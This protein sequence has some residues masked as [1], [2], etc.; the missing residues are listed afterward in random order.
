MLDH[1]QMWF[2]L[3]SAGRK[4]P[5]SALPTTLG[6]DPSSGACLR[7]P[8]VKPQHAR[9]LPGDNTTL[10]LE[11]CPGALVELDGWAVTEADLHEGDEL[12]VGQ[13]HVRLERDHSQ[14]P[15]RENDSA[16]EAP[17]AQKRQSSSRPG[18]HPGPLSPVQPT[19]TTTRGSPS[20]RTPSRQQLTS[21]RQ[22]QKS[23]SDLRRGLLH[24][25]TSQL[26]AS[27]RCILGLA[28][29]LIAAAIVWAAQALVVALS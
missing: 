15:L 23:R 21:T 28:L 3:T 7:D 2:L 24:A 26:S 18:S 14:V 11:T 6:S 20:M 22:E 5:L 8:S 17:R 4:V 16:E 27:T 9:L 29:L 19:L 12:L 1:A 25:D 13:V 10:R